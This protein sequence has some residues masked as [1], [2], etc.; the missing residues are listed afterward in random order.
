MNHANPRLII[1]VC[2]AL[3]LVGGA[4]Y[5]SQARAPHYVLA[6][7]ARADLSQESLASGN[8][9]SPT[10]AKLHFTS[11]GKLVALSVYTG[12]EVKAGTVMAKQDTS[13]LDSQLAQ[14]S[15]LANAQQAQLQNLLDGTRPEQIAVTQAQV[16]A[17][18]VAV[19]RTTAAETDALRSAFTAA[20]SALQN[21][22]DPFL[23]NPRSSTPQ[24]SFT[25]VDSSLASAFTSNRVSTGKLV[26][27]Y[28]AD[29]AIVPADP[30]GLEAEAQQALAAVSALLVQANHALAQGSPNA[31]VT[32]AQLTTWTTTVGTARASVDAASAALSAAITARQAAAANLERDQRSLSLQQAGSTQTALDAQRAT[33]AS[34]QAQADA[35]RAQ[36]R[37]LEIVA[38]FDGVVTDT[39]GTVGENVTPDV[40]IVSLMPH[41]DL[42]IKANVSEDSIVGVA[43]GDPVRIEL[44][45]F[46][47]GTA[48]SGTVSSV[49]PAQTIQGGAVYYET[50][51][52]FAQK[53]DGVKPGMTANVWIQTA[54]S[55]Q[56]LVV[57]AS[58]IT[59]TAAGDTVQ[60]MRGGSPQ[61]QAVKTGIQSQDGMIEILSGL[62]EGEQVVIGQ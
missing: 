61:I 9:E 5:F 7:V 23:S 28:G 18:Q 13:V 62:S 4:Y 22:V 58:A 30:S 47:A 14:A 41:E 50:R 49:D 20:D 42:D 16:D 56:A 27:L 54:S 32:Q 15:A 31:Q 34:A 38:P 3:T 43:P 53:Y 35:I 52:A 12:E 29:I 21:A 37:N 19:S 44:D 1:A 48:F 6:K 17:D 51:I 25:V 60:V 39:N 33:L 26:A 55:T 36:I 40:A 57:P 24:P 59:H 8:V 46:P 10:L 2:A 45:A 11:A